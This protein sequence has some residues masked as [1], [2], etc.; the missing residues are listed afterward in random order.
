MTSTEVFMELNSRLISM[1][2]ALSKMGNPEHNKKGTK[3]WD[4]KAQV[5]LYELRLKGYSVTQISQAFDVSYYVVT[6]NLSMVKRAVS[7]V[8]ELNNRNLTKQ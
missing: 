5:D 1:E 8:N 4:A 6:S 2:D 7:I 3:I